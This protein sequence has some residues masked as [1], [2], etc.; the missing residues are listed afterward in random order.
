MFKRILIFLFALSSAAQ[1][2]E[3]AWKTGEAKV[4][5]VRILT[6][7][8]EIGNQTRIV[9]AAVEFKLKKDWHIYWK[10]PGAVGLPPKLIWTQLNP[11]KADDLLFP[12]PKVIPSNTPSIPESYGY[13][14]H[15]VFPFQLHIPEEHPS[16]LNA[17]VR[18]E[19]LICSVQ[20]I[21]DRVNLE[22]SIPFGV[23]KL[24]ND[25]AFITKAFRNLPPYLPSKLNLDWV[26][27]RQIEIRSETALEQIFVYSNSSELNRIQVEVESPQ[28]FRARSQNPLSSIEIL[29]QTNDQT[30]SETHEVP[31]ENSSMSFWLA[32][33]LAFIGGA[34]LNLMPCVLPVMVLKTVS[35]LKLR[36]E[37]KSAR[38]SL[39]LTCLGILSSFAALALMTFILRDLGHSV[40][41]GFQFQ[42]PGF[43]LFMIFVV[44]LF[45]LN[46]FGVFDIKVHG[47][48]TTHASKWRGPFFEGVF[49][50]LLATPCSAPFL[51]TALTYALAQPT[52]TLFI[53]FLVM[54][55]GLA[56]PYLFFLILPA[57]LKLLPKPGPWMMGLKNFLGLSMLLACTWL[58]YVFHQIS[59]PYA[60]FKILGVLVVIFAVLKFYKSRW[61]WVFVALLTLT[62]F[63]IA[64]PEPSSQPKSQKYTV[65]SE[66]DLE[67]RL[68]AGETL[69]VVVTADWCLTC[70]YNER[71]ILE[72]DWFEA[73]LKQ[74]NAHMI[75]YDWTQQDE[76]IGSFLKKHGR[77]AIPFSMW[78]SRDRHLVLPELLTRS[79][80][81]KSW[82][83]F[84]KKP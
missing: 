16:A 24:S 35:L 11:W 75:V 21:P 42:N 2:S 61:R 73:F 83:Q 14:D 12:A 54:G 3:S 67:N 10:N 79:I 66:A 44:F 34:I 45:A 25:A 28:L 17:Q 40:G 71:L 59:G 31:P 29:A 52:P 76:R 15:V 51:G 78:I 46:F 47:K 23:E 27:D 82:E 57:S 38:T 8:Q 18:V 36:D 72:T 39:I 77:V 65:F 41:W 49:A 1:A 30:W 56:S 48:L 53:F 7:L 33:L 58:L 80:I 20:C 64:K 4:S 37:K 74:H 68:A 19:Y 55:L 69:F 60:A 32:L 43:V 22:V 13:Y 6:G 5:E 70:K 62:G 50:T 9:E 63:V 84:Q 26:D 81:K